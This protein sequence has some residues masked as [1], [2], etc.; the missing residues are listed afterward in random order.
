MR[1]QFIPV[2][3]GG[4]TINNDERE[5]PSLPPRHGGLGLKNVCNT[6]P[7]EF[8]NSRSLTITLQN[9]ILGISTDEE[10]EAVKMIC[11]IKGERRQRNKE[12]LETIKTR[13][14]EIQ[15]I[16]N[17]SNSTTEA[18]KGQSTNSAR[19]YSTAGRSPNFHRHVRV[20]FD[21]A[22]LTRFHVRKEVLL[23]CS[24]T[25]FAI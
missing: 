14:T 6:A 16:T 9:D 4:K 2:I 25:T 22:Y 24:T 20:G 13:M 17:E 19:S 15:R 11:Q 23:P 18:L 21:S 10:N 12:K 1:H 8:E 5:L 7:I 3:T